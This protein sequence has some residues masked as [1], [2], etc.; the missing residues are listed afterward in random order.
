MIS[1]AACGPMKPVKM[2]FPS[3]LS[4]G[5]Y[6][7]AA[8]SDE[9]VRFVGEAAQ[10]QPSVT[11]PAPFSGA[12]STARDLFRFARALRS[13]RILRR[14]TAELVLSPKPEAGNWSYGFDILDEQRGLVGHGGSW[15]GMSNSLD[16]FT[17][18]GHTAVI[19]S[20]YTYAR[21]PLRE[22]IWAILP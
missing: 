1:C 4:P 14:E 2:R 6:R 8:S 11:Y 12:H 9:G 16:I 5:Q 3:A 7:R 17:R 19:L 10:S 22:A 13:D 21:S 15:V 18:S 20:N